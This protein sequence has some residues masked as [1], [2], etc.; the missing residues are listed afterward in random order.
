MP[1]RGRKPGG[2]SRGKGKEKAQARDGAGSIM[3]FFKP[4]AAATTLPNSSTTAA[5]GRGIGSEGL[6]AF[7][8]D[9]GAIDLTADGDGGGNNGMAC[10]LLR[11]TGEYMHLL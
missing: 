6:V 10:K 7:S 3:S 8:G 11:S 2:S 1:L 5:P 9:S 4:S